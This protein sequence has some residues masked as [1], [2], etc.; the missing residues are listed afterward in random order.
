MATVAVNCSVPPEDTVPVVGATDM[1]TGGGSTRLLA[2]TVCVAEPVKF[3]L[4]AAVTIAVKEF[5]L[6]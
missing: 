5:A 3:A 2:V 6:M 1:E 4:S